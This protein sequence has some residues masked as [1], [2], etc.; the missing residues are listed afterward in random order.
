[1]LTMEERAIAVL[2]MLAEKRCEPHLAIG[3][4]IVGRWATEAGISEEHLED[5]LSHAGDHGWIE[6]GPRAG[7]MYVTK[8][9]LE[10]ANA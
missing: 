8:A 6:D 5:D 1:M 7:T 2:R 10:R 4:H 3:N 9:G